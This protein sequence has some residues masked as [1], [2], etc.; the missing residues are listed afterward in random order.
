MYAKHFGF[1]EL[2]FSVTPDPRFLYA[3]PVYEGAFATLLYGIEARKGFIVVIGEAGTGKTTLLRRFMRSVESTV[4]TIF[5]FDPRLSFVEL[6]R[7]VLK[8]LGLSDS[9]KDRL[10]L[11][12]RL[13]DYLVDQ[14]E[15]GHIVSLLIDE[16]QGLSD[17]LFE[18]LRLL[19]N[20]ETDKEKLIQIVLM[21][22]P[23]LER[24][25]ERPELRQ[26]KQRV[27]LRCRLAPLKSHEVA[28]YMEARLKRAGYEGR[29]LFDIAAVEK[30]ALYSAAIP[31]LINVI[32]DNALL[33]AYAA[34]KSRVSAEMVEAVA[35]DL[36][37]LDPP[38]VKR[39]ALPDG[40]EPP[41]GFEPTRPKAEERLMEEEP[42]QSEFVR[43]EEPWPPDFDGFTVGME[44][45]SD[46]FG[47]QRRL[48][49]LG[50]TLLVVVL[51][52]GSGAV[53]YS[54]HGGV[55]L[56]DLS[57][58]VEDF[59]AIGRENIAQIQTKLAALTSKETVPDKLSPVQL[60]HSPP[61]RTEELEQNS[62]AINEANQAES[63]RTLQRAAPAQKSPTRKGA[64]AVVSQVERL[65]SGPSPPAI[66]EPH[67]EI[68]QTAKTK[69]QAY[70][71]NF[72][73]VG[74]SFLRD[75]PGP[76]ANIIATLQ[77]GT[78]I[79]VV[80]KTGSYFR[81]RSLGD[82]Q[83]HGYVHREDAFFERKR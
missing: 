42:S 70:L 37:L 45:E 41:E 18:G 30:I 60:S 56:S 49:G 19:S 20:L 28:F 12:G 35:R 77:P 78:R 58:Y 39:Q 72:D 10:T 44:K 79:S 13:H 51:M 50:I 17:E 69:Q 61:L 27:A 7:L 14:L 47:S 36:Q 16:A 74:P 2:P 40:F 81:V 21:G 3:N 9:A 31:R 83:L 38:Q 4:H 68:K 26:I 66:K 64:M 73:V 46:C 71:G 48:W 33:S 52:A 57:G 6:L 8:E 59:V 43:V 67:N 82:E 23:E 15:E 5:I 54:K 55:A 1:L 29:E 11:V 34:S 76:D 80:S 32:C 22:Q 75:Q 53:L 65:G 62:A 24:K 25:L 63:S